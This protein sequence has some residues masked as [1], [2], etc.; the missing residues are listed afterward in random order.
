[1]VKAQSLNLD[2]MPFG[3]QVVWGTW[4]PVWIRQDHLVRL[5]TPR[6]PIAKSTAR[7]RWKEP[8]FGEWNRTWNRILT[9]GRRMNT[10]DCMPVE[11]W[12]GD[13]R[14]VAGLRFFIE[15]KA[16]ACLNRALVPYRRPEPRWSNHAQNEALVIRSG[17]SNRPMLKNRRMS[18]G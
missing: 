12:S 18:C 1:M 11:E 3:S 5:N 17:G 9:I 8:L 6:S 10:S 2:S 16:K 13:L 4:N 14:K 7:E 15:A